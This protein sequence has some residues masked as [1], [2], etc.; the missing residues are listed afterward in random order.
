M[1]NFI[2]SLYFPY[3]FCYIGYMA[4]LKIK[5]KE[6]TARAGMTQKEL[7][8]RLR[9]KPETVY[10]WAAGTNKPTFDIVFQLKEMG[11]TDYELFG[12]TFAEQEDAFG[13]RIRDQLRAML[14][15]LEVDTGNKEGV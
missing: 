13:R 4:R 14:G 1:L 2:K 10:K 3:S 15:E 12:K 7:A 9:V 11:M 6:F 5:V 8:E